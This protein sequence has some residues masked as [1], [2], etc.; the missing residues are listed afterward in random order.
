MLRK[1]YVDGLRGSLFVIF[2]MATSFYYQF[3]YKRFAAMIDTN[4]LFLTTL[5]FKI[6]LSNMINILKSILFYERIYKFIL[7]SKLYPRKIA[8]DFNLHFFV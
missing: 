4:I 6:F 2:M 8:S 1:I 5:T 7:K 3:F